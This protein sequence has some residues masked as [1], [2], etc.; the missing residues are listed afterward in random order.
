MRKEALS[1]QEKFELRKKLRMTDIMRGCFYHETLNYAY[2]AERGMV[3]RYYI[4][5]S[6]VQLIHC[7]NFNKY[8]SVFGMSAELFVVLFNDKPIGIICSKD[9]KLIYK[10]WP[11]EKY[12]DWD[13]R[14]ICK[15]I[16][17]NYSGP[18]KFWCL[19]DDAQ[20]L[21]E[22]QHQ[23]ALFKEH[24]KFEDD[25]IAYLW[26]NMG[27]PMTR[28]EL[29]E[30]TSM[31]YSRLDTYTA[32]QIETIAKEIVFYI[33]PQYLSNAWEEAENQIKEL[34]RFVMEQY[35]I[36]WR[37]HVSIAQAQLRLKQ[38]FLIDT[39]EKAKEYY[40]ANECSLERYKNCCMDVDYEEIMDSFEQWSHVLQEEQWSQEALERCF[41][42]QDVCQDWN[43]ER[44]LELIS[45]LH[46]EDVEVFERF[47]SYITDK[48]HEIY[49]RDI[50]IFHI[51]K[52]MPD[53]RQNSEIQKILAECCE[54]L[55]GFECKEL[56]LEEK[57]KFRKI[58]NERYFPYEK[59]R[60]V[61]C[62]KNIIVLRGST[63]LRPPRHPQDPR[64]EWSPDKYDPIE[65]S[66]FGDEG[67]IGR[68]EVSNLCVIWNV[69]E[70]DRQKLLEIYTEYVRNLEIIPPEREIRYATQEEAD[71]WE[72]RAVHCCIGNANFL[73][74]TEWWM[75][76][77]T[78]ITPSL[79]REAI[80]E[81]KT[82]SAQKE[83]DIYVVMMFSLV[84]YVLPNVERNPELCTQ[85]D[86]A[87]ISQFLSRALKYFI[88]E[89]VVPRDNTPEELIAAFRPY[90]LGNNLKIAKKIFLHFNCKKSRC[91]IC[92]DE[93]RESYN[94]F[95]ISDYEKQWTQEAF[96][97]KM[98]RTHKESRK[99]SLPACYVLD[100]LEQVGT[101][102]NYKR[103]MDEIEKYKDHEYILYR[104]NQMYQNIAEED[105][106]RL[107]EDFC[108]ELRTDVN[109]K[110]GD[111]KDE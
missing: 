47:Q 88:G 29:Q 95:D 79:M 93:L 38:L 71:N 7:H 96:D 66:F 65:I 48:L 108:E 99:Y 57:E 72:K 22:K 31:I 24:L 111:N 26:R 16:N 56:D 34:C 54:I 70:G 69:I 30:Y 102:E 53:Y 37:D 68:L 85:E 1:L 58:L 27:V 51:Q 49:V 90:C 98:E 109:G 75:G 43:V 107:V 21:W 87:C 89:E 45:D 12:R 74:Y 67:L 35:D 76:T 46:A 55:R 60:Y 61:N 20:V 13:E 103:F 73:G 33:I 4:F 110:K 19:D 25:F 78:E 104:L 36:V 32:K 3:C 6:N 15:V 17:E 41:R 101:Y 18:F 9:A 62:T 100:L 63:R 5:N 106:R 2:D 59:Y 10:F 91:V 92:Y 50:L 84:F 80:R 8:T 81:I 86:M 94:H 14:S 39:I 52:L 77:K 64:Y 40:I 44:M 82:E 42:A 97:V 11:N 83:N 28:Q 23:Q 105:V